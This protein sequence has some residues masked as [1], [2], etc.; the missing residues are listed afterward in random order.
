MA[1]DPK[2]PTGLTGP[3]SIGPGGMVHHP[4]Q[5]PTKKAEIENMIA[6]L[7]VACA[8]RMPI[9]LAPFS[10]P[11][12]NAEDDL[13][14]TV[15]TNDGSRLLELAEFAPLQDLRVGYS[16]APR[17]MSMQQT[18]QL[19][20]QLIVRKSEHQGGNGRLL[21][22]YKTHAQFFIPPPVQELVRRK[23]DQEPPAF[24]AVYFLSPHDNEQASVWEIWPG[25]PH[26]FHLKDGDEALANMR[27]TRIYPDELKKD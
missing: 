9:G 11:I 7:F 26:S 21:L 8:G 19:A 10:D 20:L 15:T 13:D 2:K 17:Q 5:F 22:L 23:L 6:R 27:L 25:A 4:V 12:R 24:E 3:I 18:A 1:N 14:F 16:D